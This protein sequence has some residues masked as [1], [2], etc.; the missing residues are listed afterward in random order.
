MRPTATLLLLL[1]ACPL[2]R[3]QIPAQAPQPDENGVYKVG[4]GI[5]AARLINHV[6]AAFPQE[7]SSR[8]MSGAC[9][10]SIVID[11]LGLPT[12][13]RLIRC[14]S[15]IFSTNPLAAIRQYRFSPAHK[16]DGTPVPVR[17]K[18]EVDFRWY[19]SPPPPINY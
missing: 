5:S 12:D 4:D 8:G 9:S 11:I 14:T 7:A 10:F 6:E 2:A 1:L 19:M 18:V 16:S 13:I 15:P 3:P 17:A